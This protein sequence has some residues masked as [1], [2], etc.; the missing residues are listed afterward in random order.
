MLS[1]L[2]GL[3]S[4]VLSLLT[5]FLPDS[6]LRGVIDALYTWDTALG[7]LNW[8]VPVGQMLAVFTLWLAALVTYTVVSYALD[9]VFDHAPTK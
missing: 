7:W 3:I 4:G 5:N 2:F 6:P 8:V 1:F 9:L